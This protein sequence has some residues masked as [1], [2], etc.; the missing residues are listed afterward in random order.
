M[1]LICI[2]YLKQALLLNHFKY[3]QANIITHIVR[4]YSYCKW[5]ICISTHPSLT[6]EWSLMCSIQFLM[7][8]ASQDSS[9]VLS[10]RQSPR[11]FGDAVFKSTIN[12]GNIRNQNLSVINISIFSLLVWTKN[13]RN[14]DRL[15]NNLCHLHS[16]ELRTWRNHWRLTF[17]CLLYSF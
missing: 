2:I 5:D 7:K 3:E 14:Q 11:H 12:Q 16:C 17:Q 10:I 15:N 4:R 1:S 13:L 9:L 8:T 6:T